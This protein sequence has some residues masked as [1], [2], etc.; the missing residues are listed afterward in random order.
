MGYTHYWTFCRPKRG[1]AKQVNKA[2]LDAIKECQNL[3]RE[4]SRV[5]GGLSGYSAHTEPG[6]YHGVN[7]NGSRENGHETFTLRE[8][9]SD[10]FKRDGRPSDFCKTAQKPYDIVV[11]ACLCVLSH[12]LGDTIAVNSDGDSIDW[13]LGLELARRITGDNRIA[14]PKLI[15]TRRLVAV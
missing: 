2:Y 6:E 10:Y 1:T 11:V 5:N 13:I 7:V 14:M 8:R 12:R 4:Y 3:I 9:L 15:R